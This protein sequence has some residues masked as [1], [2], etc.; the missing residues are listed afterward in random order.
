MKTSWAVCLAA[1][2]GFLLGAL[3]VRPRTVAAQGSIIVR[4]VEM[5]AVNGAG[6]GYSGASIVALSCVAA[7]GGTQCYIAYR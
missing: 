6:A 1:L 5:G 3:V 4:K 2:I 7:D